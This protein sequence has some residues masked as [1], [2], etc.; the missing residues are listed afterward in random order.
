[1]INYNP[2][3][4][5]QV[6]D[7]PTSPGKHIHYNVVL[8]TP[9][10]TDNDFELLKQLAIRMCCAITAGDVIDRIY[11]LKADGVPLSKY[12]ISHLVQEPL[13]TTQICYRSE[14]S[15]NVDWCRN[16]FVTTSCVDT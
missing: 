6:L 16:L 3:V 2:T 12:G 14:Y 11:K 1:M 15:T 7:T 13:P 4:C 5:R 9:P 8:L 10:K